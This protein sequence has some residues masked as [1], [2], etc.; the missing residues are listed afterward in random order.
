MGTIDDD[1][2]IDYRSP[3]LW[4]GDDNLSRQNVLANP[5]ETVPIDQFKIAADVYLHSSA[6]K[7]VAYLMRWGG[8]PEAEPMID[9][10]S[11][12]LTS[13]VSS[14]EAGLKT[15]KYE[16]VYFQINGRSDSL[17][18]E[19]ASARSLTQILPFFIDTGTEVVM[20]S[21]FVEKPFIT[22]LEAED[23][24]FEPSE[25]ETLVD[26]GATEEVQSFRDWLGNAPLTKEFFEGVSQVQTDNPGPGVSPT[27]FMPMHQ[28]IDLRDVQGNKEIS[29]TIELFFKG[30]LTKYYY[31]HSS[32]YWDSN[33][34]Y[35]LS[36]F[37]TYTTEAGETYYGP[38]A[39]RVN[40]SM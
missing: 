13:T 28:A 22:Y 35:F 32:Q 25:Y 1:L 14:E 26:A 8:D 33:S 9:L 18:P 2:V 23:Y 12:E 24:N 39:V 21:T 16:T 5:V 31:E 7:G 37:K 11:G 3:Y 17:K 34:F 27:V 40:Y 4:T 19:G 29:F 36:P 6:D 20:L 38:L 30:L 10:L 15:I